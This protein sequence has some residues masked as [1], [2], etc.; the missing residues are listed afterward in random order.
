MNSTLIFDITQTEWTSHLNSF[1]ALVFVAVGVIMTGLN[2]S[3]KRRGLPKHGWN[4]GLDKPG[5]ILPLF[6]LGL[7]LVTT[8]YIFRASYFDYTELRSA[9]E[10]GN[11]EVIEGKVENF[12]A[13][14][15]K[16]NASK[17]YFDIRHKHFVYPNPGNLAAFN[18]TVADGGP[19][20]E[21]LQV[22]IHHCDGAIARLEILDNATPDGIRQTQ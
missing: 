13:G 6:I 14:T 17:E 11:C 18:K 3:R 16:K 12:H 10:Q 1:P 21:G 8:V 2:I 7:G 4:A 9:Y 5:P 15:R 19:I 22:R 20:K